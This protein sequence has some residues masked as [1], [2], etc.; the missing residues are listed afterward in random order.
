MQRAI[1]VQAALG[2]A[3]FLLGTMAIA[4]DF[5]SVAELPSAARPMA[6]PTAA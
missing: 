5:P 2:A 3:L 6:E 1:L 4:A